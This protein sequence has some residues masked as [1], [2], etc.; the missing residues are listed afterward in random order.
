MAITISQETRAIYPV[1]NDICVKMTIDDVGTFPITKT[2][3]YYLNVQDALGNVIYQTDVQEV[4]GNINGFVHD[5]HMERELQP[6]LYT[7]MPDPMNLAAFADNQI[8]GTV[9][10]NYGENVHN[11]DTCSSEIVWLG[12][13]QFPIINGGEQIYEENILDNATYLDHTPDVIETCKGA[14]HWLYIKGSGTATITNNLA[15]QYTEALDKVTAIPVYQFGPVPDGVEWVSVASPAGVKLF[16]F[17]CCCCCEDD[18]SNLSQ[19]LYL[20]PLGGRQTMAMCIDE[21]EFDTEHEVICTH[22]TCGISIEDSY[23][24]KGRG[25]VNKSAEE[26]LK[27]TYETANNDQNREWLKAFLAS[28][29]YHILTK[30]RTGKLRYRKFILDS[31]SV[32]YSK[33]DDLLTLVVSGYYSEG[34]NTHRLD[35]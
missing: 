5:L 25:I 7:A 30:S 11:A 32:V 13:H 16:V 18:E 17:K 12:V 27:F 14:I 3:V 26:R 24:S 8:C 20:D 6:I 19:I 9:F 1:N 22:K 15:G 10:L 28:S 29:G 31:G 34:Y 4:Y 33:K 21:Y 23:N 2:I 35:I